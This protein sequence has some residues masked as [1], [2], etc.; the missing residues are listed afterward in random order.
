MQAEL[1]IN[2]QVALIRRGTAEIISESE[3][4]QKLEV[5][6][7]EKRALRIKLGLD[8]T[9]PDIH[10]G[11]A[12]VL[13]KLRQFPRPRTRGYPYHRRFHSDNRGS[14]RQIENTTTA[15]GGRGQT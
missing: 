15:D 12:V 8:P 7:T 11:I 10:L 5:A 6:K 4:A 14:E 3:L 9:A 1:S 2:E 13:R